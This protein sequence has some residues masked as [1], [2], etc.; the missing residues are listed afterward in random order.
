MVWS[1]L[2]A[3]P[4]LAL[5]ALWLIRFRYHLAYSSPAELRVVAGVRFLFWEKVLSVDP[6]RAMRGG[7]SLDPDE[8]VPAPAPPTD[9][10]LAGQRGALRL[11]DSWLKRLA[12]LQ[13]RFRLAGRK[14]ILDPGM[15]RAVLLYGWR[16]G[17]RSLWLVRPRLEML[18]L[19]LENAYDLSRIASAWSVAAATVPALRCPVTYGWGISEAELR[20]RV[21]GRFT[22]L[23]VAVLGLVSLTTFPWAALA[24]RFAQCWRDPAL[25]RWQRRVLL[26]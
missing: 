15:W 3:V 18:H 22:G 14:W 23:G 2:A 16:S 6:L 8:P 7:D 19:G 9:P 5:L 25:T 17:R 26:P 20:L 21:G 13:E 1:L 10:G 4:L 24:R 11:P 12:R